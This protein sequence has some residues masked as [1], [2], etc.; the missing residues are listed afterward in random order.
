M[1]S[2]KTRKAFVQMAMRLDWRLGHNECCSASSPRS[3]SGSD[4]C[5]RHTFAKHKTEILTQVR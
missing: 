5:E 1:D 2:H 4:L 3:V